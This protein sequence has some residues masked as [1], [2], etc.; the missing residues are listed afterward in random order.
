VI[1]HTGSPR[2]SVIVPTYNRPIALQRCVASLA[3]QA[4]SLPFEVVVVDDGGVLA[5]DGQAFESLPNLVMIRQPHAGAAAARMTGVARARGA[6]LAFVDDDCTVPED[7][8]QSIEH[9][10]HDHPDT[11]VAQVRILNPEPGNPYG[12]LWD[13]NLQRLRQVN[14]HRIPDGRALSGT[15]GGVMV[16]RRDVFLRVAYD[17]RLNVGLEDADLRYQL[18]VAGIDV[19]YAPQIRV[20]HHVPDTLAGY[21]A[22]FIRYGRG[23]AQ[24]RRKWGATPAPFRSCTLTGSDDF[25]A[26]ARAEGLR[27][28]TAL[29]GALWLRRAALVLGEVHDRAS[30]FLAWANRRG[31]IDR[32]RCD[33]ERS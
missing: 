16:A 17:P 22:Q 20:Y 8:I 30:Q 24:L 1:R 23:A 6:V 13:F 9:V 31:V 12:R 15:L 5:T 3:R 10:F 4:V 21:L 32:S 11:Q 7:Y 14:L 33:R 18:Y 27:A 25:R 26:L 28:G 2:I 29:Y 19:H